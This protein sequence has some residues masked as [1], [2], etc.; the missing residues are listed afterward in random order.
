MVPRVECCSS[1]LQRN[2]HSWSLARLQHSF[3]RRRW[4]RLPFLSIRTKRI[5]YSYLGI[6][7]LRSGKVQT[8]LLGWAAAA[9]SKVQSLLRLGWMVNECGNVQRW[10]GSA[11]L[12]E[13]AKI[14][15]SFASLHFW[16]MFLQ[17]VRWS[18]FSCCLDKLANLGQK[19]NS[20]K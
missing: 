3:V 12:L 18:S 4:P 20:L 8:R 15:L 17:E 2:A 5:R 1:H 9:V 11:L 13:A 6:F 7:K 14:K 19:K 16:N 10:L